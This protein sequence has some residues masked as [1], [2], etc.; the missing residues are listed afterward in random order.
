MYLD[1]VDRIV[2]FADP[3]TW[4]RLRPTG[5]SFLELSAEVAAVLRTSDAAVARIRTMMVLCRTRL[6]QLTMRTLI[7]RL[8]IAG[9][10]YA[11]AVEESLDAIR[12]AGYDPISPSTELLARV[13]QTPAELDSVLA[14]LDT[15]EGDRQ[16]MEHTNNNDDDDDLVHA[17]LLLC[18][19]SS[20]P[21][22]DSFHSYSS[23]SP[24]DC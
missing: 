11:D 7:I 4:A 9:A 5:F 14:A 23:R 3:P 21:V 12:R 16:S 15:D 22:L 13:P 2:D 8:L 10:K 17:L 1:S 19:P 6:E 20:H 24:A 18:G